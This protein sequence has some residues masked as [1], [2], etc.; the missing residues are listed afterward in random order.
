MPRFLRNFR[1]SIEYDGTDFNGWQ[2]Q[3][4]GCRTVQGEIERAL[5]TIFG[6]KI[7]LIGAGRTDAGVHALA[8]V[9]NFKVT[10]RL[11]APTLQKA[12]NAH[13]P[14][15]IAVI[16]VDEVRLKFHAQ[17]DAKGKIYRYTILNRSYR[18]AQERRFVHHFP[19]KLNLIRM[20]AAARYLVGRH[21]FRSF[22]A[23]D[24]AQ[25]ET[26]P[27]KDTK[28]T[29]GRIDIRRQGDLVSIEIEGDGFLYKMVRNIVGVLLEVGTKRLEPTSVKTLLAQ[30]DRKFVSPTA[31]AQGLCLVKVIY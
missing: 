28:R 1:L 23:T 18:N 24:S 13:L 20:K 5:K 21:D 30:K 7:I 14:P 15:D 26:L 6:K 31:P 10:T 9:S 25:R 22:M 3:G 29:I 27:T 12:L 8:H 19:Y 4:Q 17:F 11:D 2:V 16:G